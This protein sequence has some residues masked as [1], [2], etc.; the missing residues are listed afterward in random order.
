MPDTGVGSG[1]RVD[2]AR[3]VLLWRCKRKVVAAR[4]ALQRQ[5]EVI[6]GFY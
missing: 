1:A 2:R 5:V 3:R 6:A 4:P